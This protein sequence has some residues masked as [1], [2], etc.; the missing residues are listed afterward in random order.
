MILFVLFLQPVPL[1]QLLVLVFFFPRRFG[2][3]RF[4]SFGSTLFLTSSNFVGAFM[5]K[6][7]VRM[8]KVKYLVGRIRQE[9]LKSSGLLTDD[10]YSL[11]AFN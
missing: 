5:M 6:I 10:R 8:M 1:V 2:F 3:V 11:I 7:L 9:T 4:E